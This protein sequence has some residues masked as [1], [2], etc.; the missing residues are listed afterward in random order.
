MSNNKI[1]MLS[2]AQDIYV[3][4]IC[5]DTCDTEDSIYLTHLPCKHIFH[6]K[7]IIP[8]FMKSRTT[9]CPLC[10]QEVDTSVT[11]S[12]S[13]TVSDDSPP[14]QQTQEVTQNTNERYE[15]SECT[16][17]R[18]TVIIVCGCTFMLFMKMLEF[19]Y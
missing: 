17:R 6:S 5:L 9:S 3:C 15:S 19:S 4:S 16:K 13:I 12:V 8:Y 2:M 18:L 11:A 10:R 14:I 7:C 1:P